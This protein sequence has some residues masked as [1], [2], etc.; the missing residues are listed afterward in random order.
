[1]K[2]HW[3][4]CSELLEGKLQK[5]HEARIGNVFLLNGL[6]TLFLS[7]CDHVSSWRYLC[8]SGI[9]EISPALTSFLCKFA[10]LGIH[11]SFSLLKYLANNNAYLVWLDKTLPQPLLSR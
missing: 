10:I 2:N 1:M 11:D 8:Q 9:R 6:E 3:D 5:P 4:W 7:N